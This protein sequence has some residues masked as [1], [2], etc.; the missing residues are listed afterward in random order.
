MQVLHESLEG[1]VVVLVAVN[2]AEF[3]VSKPLLYSKLI[4]II[5][6]EPRMRETVCQRGLPALY[7]MTCA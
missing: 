3:S 1:S 2:A 6:A 5:K 4:L 7:Y